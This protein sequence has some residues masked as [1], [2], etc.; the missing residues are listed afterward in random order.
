MTDSRWDVLADALKWL[1]TNSRTLEDMRWAF[2]AGCVEGTFP[3]HGWAA[4]RGNEGFLTLRNL[5]VATAATS[6]DFTL[7]EALELPLSSQ[8]WPS[9]EA[10]NLEVQVEKRLA[11]QDSIALEDPFQPCAFLVGSTDLG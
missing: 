3:P 1:R 9:G 11:N 4:W 6:P 7:A 5:Q 10:R 2:P 8:Q